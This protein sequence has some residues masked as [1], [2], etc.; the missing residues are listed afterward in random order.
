M[1]TTYNF[2]ASDLEG[3]VK[4]FV[5]CLTT[6]MSFAIVQIVAGLVATAFI[7]IASFAS[8][9]VSFIMIPVVAFGL[10]L[11]G[12]TAIVGYAIVKG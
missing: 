4:T 6:I 9:V 3:L 8:L 11:F 1:I 7:A 10:V 12:I 5:F 2:L